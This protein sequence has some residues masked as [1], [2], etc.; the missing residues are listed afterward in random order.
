MKWTEC[1]KTFENMILNFLP[2]NYKSISF[3]IKFTN[4]PKSD[5]KSRFYEFSKIPNSKFL[6]IFLNL[7]DERITFTC[8]VNQD[9]PSLTLIPTLLHHLSKPQFKNRSILSNLSVTMTSYFAHQRVNLQAAT[10]SQKPKEAQKKDPFANVNLKD[11]TCN[12]KK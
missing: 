7:E 1:L 2:Q 5:K 12:F 6:K 4:K 9:Q 11:T 3:V 8:S 10:Q